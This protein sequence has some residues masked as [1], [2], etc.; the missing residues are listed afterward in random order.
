MRII[1]T[2]AV[3]A[4]LG[5]VGCSTS[6]TSANNS[7]NPNPGVSNSDLEQN[8]KSKLAA[9]PRTAGADLGVSA[10]ASKNQVTLSGTLYS[11]SARTEA[12]N[13]AKAAQPGLDVVDKIEVKPGEVPRSAYTDDM[14]RQAR[15]QARTQGDKIG[16]SVEDAWI[17]TK[18]A[19]KLVTNSETPARDIHIDVQNGVVTLRGTV[20]AAAQKADA[21]RVAKD[22]DGV[23]RVNNLLHV[24]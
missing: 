23:K 12:I 8:V 6:S 5:L 20:G 1:I 18:I 13:D 3:S 2:F 19:S 7:T 4:A 9:D 16:T 24:G 21:G 14:A 22:T 17:H 11:E 10:D 15:E